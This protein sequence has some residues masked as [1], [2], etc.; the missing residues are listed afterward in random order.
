MVASLPLRY[1]LYLNLPPPGHF[2]RTFLPRHAIYRAVQHLANRIPNVSE[3]RE[4]WTKQIIALIDNELLWRAERGIAVTSIVYPKPDF[5]QS[6]NWMSRIDIPL[7]HP[8]DDRT[9]IVFMDIIPDYDL[10]WL[11]PNFPVTEST[12]TYVIDLEDHAFTINGIMHFAL[13]RMPPDIS[14]CLVR[15]ST[16]TTYF[17]MTPKAEMLYSTFVRRWSPV[18]RVPPERLVDSYDIISPVLTNLEE[19][20]TST[21]NELNAS[22]SL[23]VHLVETILRDQSTQIRNPDFLDDRRMFNFCQWQLITAAAPLAVAFLPPSTISNSRILRPQINISLE[24]RNRPAF[25][26]SPYRKKIGLSNW[27]APPPMWFRGCLIILCHRLDSAEFVK[28]EVFHMVQTLKASHRNEGLGLVF[29]GRNVVGVALDNTFIRHTPALPVYDH[30]LRL[31]DGF[32][33]IMHLLSPCLLTEKAPWRPSASQPPRSSLPLPVEIIFRI[34]QLV[35]CDNYNVLPSV[36]YA[37]RRLHFTYPR[38]GN[39][40]LLRAI[41]GGAF[42][43]FDTINQQG[44]CVR[45]NRRMIDSHDPGFTFYHCQSKLGPRFFTPLEY[46]TQLNAPRQI[47]SGLRDI[48]ILHCPGMTHIIRLGLRVLNMYTQD[49]NEAHIPEDVGVTM[50]VVLGSWSFEK[51]KAVQEDEVW[52]RYHVARES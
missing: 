18:H 11:C 2:F 7:D 38:F 4:K 12:W 21:W 45:F 13:D 48:H 33:L 43:A 32:R 47:S 50:Q 42:R 26:Y 10:D 25:S 19:W 6:L 31:M 20:R 16:S 23:A 17:Q 14:T 24:S 34:I 5:T 49:R 51:V 44:C 40:I 15:P 27:H 3:N 1:Y 22:E 35:D 8:V 9:Q 41:Q 36:S 37:F 46:A 28:A 29:D 52:Y 30:Q 39:V